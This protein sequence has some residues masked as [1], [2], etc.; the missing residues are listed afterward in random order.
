VISLVNGFTEDKIPILEFSN[1]AWSLVVEVGRNLNP[2]HLIHLKT[3]QVLAD[4]NYRYEMVIAPLGVAGFQGET[5]SCI[6]LLLEDWNID[7]S[8]HYTDLVFS[9]R[10]NFGAQGPT[11][12]FITHSFR[13]SENDDEFQERV[14]IVHKNGY[15]QHFIE[16]MRF[17]FCKTLFDRAAGTWVDE[18]ES[19][20]LTP[21]PLRRR[22]GQLID[23][24]LDFF[25]AAD[26]FPGYWIPAIEDLPLRVSEAWLWGNK[27]V[28]C[29]SCL[30][31]SLH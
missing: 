15:D 22:I 5:Q 25:S 17:G 2:I 26:L 4:K 3:D 16:K 31:I 9:A 11:D 19:K 7:R 10:C 29:H 24:K 12:I 6:E 20:V 1:P 18:A 23:H 14:S 27:Q 28:C 30:S 21:V 13:L 8:D